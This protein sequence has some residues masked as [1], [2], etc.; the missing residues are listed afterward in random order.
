MESAS[1]LPG[2]TNGEAK[3]G[4][5][6]FYRP[7]LDVLRFF[8]FF[9]V[10]LNHTLSTHVISRLAGASQA[11]GEWLEALHRSGGYGVDLFFTLSAYLITELLLRER[12]VRGTID[13]W[14]FYLRRALRIWPLYYVF[15]LLCL[16]VV[17]FLL[18]AENLPAEYAVAFTFFMGNWVCAF[19]GY[20]PSAAALLWSVSIEEQFYLVWPLLLSRGSASRLK[21]LPV[22]LV[23]I[24]FLN[25]VPLVGIP[26]PAMWCNTFARLDAIAAGAGLA[27]ALNFRVPTIRLAGRLSLFL[28]GLALWLGVARYYEWIGPLGLISYPMVAAGSVALLLSALATPPSHLLG[29]LVYLGRISYGLYVFHA[30]SLAMAHRWLGMLGVSSPFSKIALGFGLTVGLAAASYEWLE[31]PFLRLKQRFTHVTS[32]TD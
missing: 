14:S 10:F 28:F 18:P 1:R 4:D 26:H 5:T 17:P 16:T 23:G 32:R 30:L 11:R 24:A 2:V 20:P 21:V 3:S 8:A 9:A 13:V 27:L 29:P 12:S 22:V 15:I 7:Q 6:R 19:S 25:R 31:R